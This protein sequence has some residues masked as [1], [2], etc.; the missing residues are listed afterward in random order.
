MASNKNDI[1]TMHIQRVTTNILRK[2]KGNNQS[3]KEC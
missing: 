3:D 1:M 2:S